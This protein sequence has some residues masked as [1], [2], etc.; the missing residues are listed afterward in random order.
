MNCKNNLQSNKQYLLPSVFE[1]CKQKLFNRESNKIEII[2]LEMKHNVK[3]LVI[4][5]K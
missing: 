2:K 4:I 1:E 3:K 5:K